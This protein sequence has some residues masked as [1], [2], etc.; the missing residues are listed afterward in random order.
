VTTKGRTFLNRVVALHTD[1]HVLVAV[2]SVAHKVVRAANINL[3]VLNPR[4]PA[5]SSVAERER[6]QATFDEARVYAYPVGLDRDR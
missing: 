2:G 3:K 1:L 6:I 4:S 5:R